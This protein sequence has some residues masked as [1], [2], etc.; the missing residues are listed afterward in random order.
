M[1]DSFLRRL[2]SRVSGADQERLHRLERAVAKAAA[3]QRDQSVHVQKQLAA[4]VELV[5]QRASAKDSGE[6]RDAVRALAT[7]FERSVDDQ[8]AHGG[9]AEQQRLNER[10]LFK[11]LDQIA[12]SS[13][14]IVVGPWSGEVGF[15]LLYWVPFLEWARARWALAADRFVVVSRGGVEAWYGVTGGRYLD[16]F[17]ALAPERFREAT[18]RAEHKQR[19]TSSLDTEILEKLKAR[20]LPDGE[21]LHPELMY[22]TFMPF[23]RDEA[24]FATVEAF[25]RYR[26]FTPVPDPVLSRLPADYVAVRFYFSDCFPAT[27][28]NRAFARTVVSTIA[29]RTPVVLLNPGIQ[30]DEHVDFTPEIAQRVHTIGEAIAPERNLAVQSAII[31]KARAFVGTYG[32]YSYLAPF[33]GVPALAFY[34]SR[35]FKLHHLHVAARVFAGLGSASVI[36][37][38][39]A[40]APIVQLALG[41][42]LSP[43]AS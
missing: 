31:A 6:I 22:R 38:D 13:A 23:W 15:E 7:Q 5:E 24:G 3:A 19:R 16:I 39:V 41:S 9:V 43:A 12:A 35:T 29:A 20:G 40:H 25:T 36:P 37:V 11:R 10:R 30:V 34:S 33:Y 14:P 42:V 2:V 21:L 32:G 18:S 17:S 27:S 28:E 26:S 8:L 4:L 1:S